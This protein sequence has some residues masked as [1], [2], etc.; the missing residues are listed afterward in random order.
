MDELGSSRGS[1]DY[2]RG[3]AD[4]R[5]LSADE[6]PRYGDRAPLMLIVEDW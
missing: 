4:Y 1:D 5:L 6:F 3:K 2:G